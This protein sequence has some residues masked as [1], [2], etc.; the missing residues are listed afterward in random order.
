MTAAAALHDASPGQGG[1]TLL[2]CDH[3]DGGLAGLPELAEGLGYPCDYAVDAHEDPPECPEPAL[4]LV[5]AELPGGAAGD[6]WMRLRQRYPAPPAVAVSRTRSFARAVEFF[7]AGADDFLALPLDP[8][9]FSSRLR[10]L[11]QRRAA[12]T[13]PPAG[14]AESPAAR[15][16]RFAAPTDGDEAEPV[17][18]TVEWP[19]PPPQAAPAEAAPSQAA[20]NPP[21]PDAAAGDEDVLSSMAG[22][23]LAAEPD[24]PPAAPEAGGDDVLA[25]LDRVEDAWAWLEAAPCGWIVLDADG[26]ARLANPAALRLLGAEDAA[27]AARLLAGDWASLEAE[28]APGRPAAPSANPAARA[29][30]DKAA[31]ALTARV[32]RPDGTRVWLRFECAPWRRRGRFAGVAAVIVNVTAERAGAGRS[33]RGEK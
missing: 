32:R 5:S 10:S 20:P 1:P 3:A 2:V 22:A 29:A 24:V 27:R 13:I 28:L 19:G 23:E 7:R 4:L 30:R 31:R 17:E 6:A 15:D 12:K 21:P 14:P 33:G 11:L 8:S 18:V 26:A 25:E 16:A 9:E